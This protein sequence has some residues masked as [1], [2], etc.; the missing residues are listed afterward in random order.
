MTQ[1]QQ[2]NLSTQTLKSL[3][4]DETGATFQYSGAD[5]LYVTAAVIKARSAVF[6]NLARAGAGECVKVKDVRPVNG[7]IN[8]Y[9]DPPQ[10]ATGFIVLHRFDQFPADISDVKTVRKYIPIKQYQLDSAIVLDTLEEKKYFFSVFAEFKR[11][12]EK[13]YSVGTDYL[14]DNSSKLNITYSINVNK[15]FF[16]ESS[17]VLEFEAEEKEFVLP[18]IEIMSAIGHTPMFKASADLFYTIPSQSVNGSV[19]IR[20]PIAKNM[21][22]DTYIKAFFKDE[23]AQNGNQLRLK[24]KSNYKVS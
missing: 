5:L 13:D 20:V 16:G 7:K 24:V 4:S 8:I 21:P 18:E 2:Q 6:G 23:S 17:V 10:G 9:I 1:L 15:K 12:G 22:R 11:D 19:Q 3:K 14:F